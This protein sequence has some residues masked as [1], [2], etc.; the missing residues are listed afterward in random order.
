MG[1]NVSVMSIN[2][3]EVQAQKVN[4]KEIGRGNFIKLSNNLFRSMNIMMTAKEGIKIWQD[5][6]HLDDATV[7]NG[8]TS[9]IMSNLY[10][11]D[12]I[13]KVKP[14]AGDI[15]IAVPDTIKEP[16]FELLYS[17]RGRKVTKEV[18]FIGMNRTT[19]DK[20]GT[21]IN[22]VF[23]YLDKFL[24]QIDFE[25]LPFED[26]G[27]TEWARFSHSSSFSDAEAGV[28]AVHH[29]YLIRAMIGALSIREDIIIATPKS[30][31]DK[32]T[33]S[34][35]DTVARMLKFS[36]DHGVRIAY[37]PMID[38]DGKTVSLDGK[39]VWQEIPTKDSNYKKTVTEIFSLAFKDGEKIDSSKLWTF[40]GVLTLMKKYLTKKQTQQCADR[41]FEMLWGNQGQRLERDNPEED[42]DVKGSGWELFKKTLG[43]KDPNMFE[44]RLT[45]YYMNY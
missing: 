44:E 6:K 31:W 26:C 42:A 41:Y 12:E 32:I 40:V 9:F 22:C 28:K 10:T 14:Q 39:E 29:K 3:E 17:L 15:D 11:D 20:L 43:V 23:K 5:E 13:L 7:Y 30:Q 16:L 4:L 1:G 25:F 21:Q 38:L 45:K 35:K 18:E 34:K 33:V 19:A 8:S 24:V 2:D 36:V 37:R 27:P